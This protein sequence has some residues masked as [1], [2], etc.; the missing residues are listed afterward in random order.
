MVPESALILAHGKAFCASIGLFV[1]AVVD[2][3]VV[4]GSTEDYIIKGGAA[5][6]IIF[7]VRT[8]LKAW[9]DHKSSMEEHRRSLE[10]TISL[11]T[12]AINKVHDALEVQI[13]FFDGIG[14]DAI[15]HAMN[16]E[17]QPP[18]PPQ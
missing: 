16:R 13:R 8:I 12:S 15:R 9:D 3:A 17:I 5:G 11:N 4:P 18:R 6:L 10:T 7:L 1:V 2:G 14:Q